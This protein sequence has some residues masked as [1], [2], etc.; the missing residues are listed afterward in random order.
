[1]GEDGGDRGFG[2]VALYRHVN[3]GERVAFAP[4]MIQSGK[5]LWVARQRSMRSLPDASLHRF[6]WAI[7]PDR[8]AVVSQKCAIAVDSERTT[9]QSQHGRPPTLDPAHVLEQ[10]LAF[11]PPELG[12]ATRREQL[13]N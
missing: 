10:D 7:Q 1:M 9:A 12:F 13:R 8:D 6:K 5:R 3:I 2:I 11:D 4:R